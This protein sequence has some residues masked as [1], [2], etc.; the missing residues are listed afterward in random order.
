MR[1][2]RAQSDTEPRFIIISTSDFLQ[3]IDVNTLFFF[4]TIIHYAVT[5]WILIVHFFFFL[6]QSKDIVQSNIPISNFMRPLSSVVG[7]WEYYKRVIC[8]ASP[9]CYAYAYKTVANRR[10][11]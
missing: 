1:R 8:A 4:L 9:W 2:P 3:N 11:N 10:E 5:N 6:H 7:T